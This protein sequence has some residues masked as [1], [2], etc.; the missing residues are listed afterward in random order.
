MR[1]ATLAAPGLE[2]YVFSSDGSRVLTADSE[3]HDGLVGADGLADGS[4]HLNL[5]AHNMFV[6]TEIKEADS[7]VYLANGDIVDE[8]SQSIVGTLSGCA[9]SRL[10]GSVRA[11][12]GLRDR[13]GVGRP[14]CL[15]PFD[16]ARPTGIGTPTQLLPSGAH[17]LAISGYS[18]QG[19][20][21]VGKIMLIDAAP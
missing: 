10:A 12:P 4:M 13:C 6:L 8:A 20:Q 2:E 17:G 21:Y 1:P 3:V 7:E 5:G 19:S 9:A 14:S 16:S 11:G 15:S 18:V